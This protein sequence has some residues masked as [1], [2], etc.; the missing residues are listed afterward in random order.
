MTDNFSYLAFSVFWCK[1]LMSFKLA[2]ED[3]L[4][5]TKC[6]QLSVV[7]AKPYFPE[8]YNQ[9]YNPRIRKVSFWKERG[10]EDH[11]F[12][13][14]NVIDGCHSICYLLNKRFHYAYTKCTMSNKGSEYGFAYH[15][16]YADTNSHE[17]VIMAYQDPHWVFYEEGEPLDFEDTSLYKKRLKKDRLNNEIIKDYLLKLG[18]DFNKMGTEIEESFTIID[19]LKT[20]L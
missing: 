19:N 16:L 11:I 20:N 17:R 15:F 1:D 4:I 7:H 14:S 12:F 8:Y 9:Q 3:I 10:N 5:S 18:I 2:L 13:L 6:R